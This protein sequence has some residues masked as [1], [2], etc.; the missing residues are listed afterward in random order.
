MALHLG[1]A[2]SLQDDRAHTVRAAE[3]VDRTEGVQ[4]GCGEAHGGGAEQD[5]RDHLP[6]QPQPP[7]S[8]GGWLI[9]LGV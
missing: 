4:D 1:V 7:G 9:E 3:G 2:P 6:V 8:R 5:S